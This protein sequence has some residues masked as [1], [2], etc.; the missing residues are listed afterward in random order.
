[1]VESNAYAW[2][3]TGE[4]YYLMRVAD[5]VDWLK[6]SVWDG[7]D[8]DYVRGYY[9]RGSHSDP[10]QFTGWALQYFP[11]A[12][13]TLEEAG[14]RPEPVPDLFE[15]DM[16]DP[17]IAIKKQ[18]GQSITLR[19]RGA[20]RQWG[21]LP[22]R[23]AKYSINGPDGTRIMSNT[24]QMQE[25]VHPEIPAEAPGGTYTLKVENAGTL[26]VPVTEQTDIPEVMIFRAGEEVVLGRYNNQAWFYVPGDID[27]FQVQIPLADGHYIQRISIWNPEGQR[28]WD[29][30]YHRESYKGEDPVMAVIK[31]EPGQADRLWRIT[32]PG[33]NSRFT[34]DLKIP[35]VYS[36]AR[37]R[38]FMP[39]SIEK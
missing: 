11:L 39:E 21:E 33:N 31:V 9:A 12:L 16:P 13:A 3:L 5:F 24:W 30:H 20:L 7:E 10:P 8:P 27:Q 17:V 29:M 14:H 19:L 35:P 25:N 2:Q 36:V 23:T 34:M 22:K 6:V 28:A 32:L 15:I 38:W 1:M 18:P 37:D 4:E 26:V